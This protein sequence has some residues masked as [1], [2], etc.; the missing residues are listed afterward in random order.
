MP[1]P[2]ATSGRSARRNGLASFSS[3]MVTGMV[4]RPF[5]ISPFCL[6]FARGQHRVVRLDGAREL[7]VGGGVFVAAIEFGVVR[8]V[9]QLLERAPTSSPGCPRSRAR[10][11]WRTACRRRRRASRRAANRRCARACGPG[12][13]I[14][15]AVSVPTFT[16][17]PSRTVSS[18][19]G[20]LA[21]SFAGATT[22]HLYLSLSARMPSVWSA[23]WCVTRMSVS[24]QPVCLSA[25]FDRRRFRRVDRGG[26][27]GIGVVQQH[28]VII[29]QA[30]E[31]MGLGGHGS[32]PR[33]RH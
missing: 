4:G 31:Q 22:R 17:S 13:S 11:R 27:A 15:L 20:I 6:H 25:C 5:S 32:N 7:D 29:F 33:I 16:L 1:M 19:A 18:T 8:Q 2:A 9:A 12:V 23:W 3:P 10:S 28:A 30:Q 26:G 21:A 24:F 14:T